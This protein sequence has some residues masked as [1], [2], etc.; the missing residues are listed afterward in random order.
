MRYNGV[1]PARQTAMLSDKTNQKAA[2]APVPS[3]TA[4]RTPLPGRVVWRE[5]RLAWLPRI[6]IV[7][8][9]LGAGW[10]WRAPVRIVS[11]PGVSASLLVEQSRS[12]SEP[13]PVVSTARKRQASLLAARNA[14]AIPPLGQSTNILFAHD[15]ERTLSQ[16]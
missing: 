15:P 16:H 13:D 14:P 1:N 9:M 4:A 5:F 2:C 8:S 3:R 6:M 12:A 11:P 7:A 10:L